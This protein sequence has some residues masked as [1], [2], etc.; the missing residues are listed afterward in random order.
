[1]SNLD[2]LV[3]PFCGLGVHLNRFNGSL[4]GGVPIM[5][6]GDFGYIIM[7]MEH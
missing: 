5:S 1:M 2:F 6:I 7:L 3:S 4:D